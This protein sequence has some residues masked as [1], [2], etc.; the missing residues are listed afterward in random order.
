MAL[1]KRLVKGSPLTFQEGDDNL[2]YL[3]TL[4]TNTG[5]FVTTSSFN[6]YTASLDPG[7]TKNIGDN[8]YLFYNFS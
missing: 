5:S 6:A 2:D 3:E 8:L 7:G 4:A 1:T